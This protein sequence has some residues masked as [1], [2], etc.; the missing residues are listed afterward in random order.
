LGKKSKDKKSE[1]YVMHV[2]NSGKKLLRLIDDIIDIS[3][4]ESNQLTIEE[5][6]CNIY[7]LALESILLY[8][9]NSMLKS[10]GLQLTYDLP[11]SFKQL[12]IKT[13]PIRLKQIIDN[14][15]SNAIKYSDKG[16]IK[17]QLQQKESKQELLF[18]ITDTGI[19]IREGDQE[20]VFNRFMQSKTD[21]IS[22]GTGLGL[23]ICKGLLDLMGGKIWIDSDIG[24]G[25]VFYFTI[26]LVKDK[27]I[28]ENK[29]ISKDENNENSFNG[30]LI[31]IA[32]D[33]MSSFLL[34]QEILLNTGAEIVH[35]QNGLELL[36]QLKDRQPD[37]I[38][39]DINMPIMDGLTFM[40]QFKKL[41]FKDIPVIAQTAYA[42]KIEKE[43]CLK[44]GCHDYISKPIDAELLLQKI[45]DN[46]R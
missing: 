12:V 13:D 24:K 2:K 15:L 34:I 43:K 1:V 31:Y 19:G 11:E 36:E 44:A 35:S 8:K 3:K 18:S 33:D 16:E 30:K 4:I 22:D 10:K 29:T 14:L 9:E 37:L 17:L 38:L 27:I 28:D 46:I 41:N 25:S 5:S 45:K 40:N 32:E 20:N 7:N 6:S 26:P 39:L 23:S 21:R 42:M